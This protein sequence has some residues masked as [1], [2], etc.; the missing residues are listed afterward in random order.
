VR[1][2]IVL[3]TFTAALLVGAGLL[4]TV[5]PMVAKM[6]LPVLGGSPSVWTGC[7]LFYQAALLAGYALAHGLASRAKV[8]QVAV[9]VA[10]LLLAFLALPVSL[11]GGTP[12]PGSSPMVWL[13]VR[14][15]LAVGAPFVVVSAVA[16]L[17]QRWFSMTDH[18]SA[19]DPYFLYASS[20]LGSLGALLA[21]PFVIEPF[22]PLSSQS[23]LWSIG[24]V[25]LVVVVAACAGMVLRSRAS[26]PTSAQKTKAARRS[27]TKS[28]PLR[29]MLYAF[30]PSS[31]ML[32]A[33]QYLANDLVSGPFVWVLPLAAYLLSFVLTFARRPWLSVERSGLALA[34]LCVAV[35]VSMWAFMRP[36]AW[37]LPLHPLVVLAA[38]LVCHGRL[39]ADRPDP[40][41]LTGFYL[42]VA[43]GGALGGVFN[44]LVAPLLFNAVV[45]YPLVMVL[46][47]FVRPWPR[48]PRKPKGATA[49]S[50]VLFA[51]SA[52][53]VAWG[54]FA[55]L[56]AAG[57]E[58]PLVVALGAVGIPAVAV[59]IAI[60]R[61]RAFALGLGVLFV[62][63]WIQT[64]RP[65]ETL[66][67]T[68]TFFG[69]H[70]VV[71]RNSDPFQ[72]SSA[73]G[74]ERVFVVP[75]RILYHGT[76]RHG[77]QIGDPALEVVPGSYYHES[78]PVGQVFDI[79]GGDSRFDSIAVVGLGVGTLAAYGK[80]GQRIDFYEL[81]PEVLRI[82]RDSGHFTW[83]R[84]SDAETRFIIGDGRVSLA[85]VENG[86]YDLIVVDA[87]SS[88]AIPVHLLTREAMRLYF[89][90]LRPDGVLALHVTNQYLDLAPVVEALAHDLDLATLLRSDD[91][92]TAEHKLEGK[93]RSTWAVLARKR[94]RIAALNEGFEWLEL[95]L[96]GEDLDRKRFLWTDDYANVLAVLRRGF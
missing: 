36:T 78:G 87:F 3:G 12:S 68:R 2:A 38:G 35:L 6:L 81:D 22:V 4:F 29:W 57:A 65:L 74:S 20:N 71:E 23:R 75:Q 82:A 32:G 26:T 77:L 49:A 8:V 73:N 95:P 13:L 47:C 51:L 84:D 88:D 41:R 96:E 80:A 33:T 58:S 63:A 66:E 93:Y 62:T 59:L 46:A 28:S 18:P 5:E 55:L 11:G 27:K 67:Q 7:M 90:K 70:R 76:T 25:F 39:A 72:S 17:L 40:S 37:M 50:D 30:V 44:A 85:E 91:V 83:L 19:G 64:Q 61:P 52:G 31:V 42:W 53:A 9:L 69:V 15:V 54:L 24:Y 21:Y 14:L 89:D 60:R 45:E 79:L 56:A 92:E 86:R 43:V 10:F 16:P 34:V 48:T 1:N 94:E